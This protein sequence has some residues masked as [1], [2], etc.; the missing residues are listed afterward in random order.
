MARHSS[1]G[2]HLAGDCAQRVGVASTVRCSKGGC[3]CFRA[4]N[5]KAPYNFTGKETAD[6][7]G[8]RLEDESVFGVVECGVECSCACSTCGVGNCLS[9]GE[10]SQSQS[11][12]QQS[13]HQRRQH[14]CSPPPQGCV[15]R[16]INKAPGANAGTG[17]GAGAGASAGAAAA[18]GSKPGRSTSCCDGPCLRLVGP[19]GRLGVRIKLQHMGPKGW[20]VLAD[21]ELT[22]GEYVGTYVGEILSEAQAKEREK[23]YS[24]EGVATSYVLNVCGTSGRNDYIKANAGGAPFAVDATRMGNFA[25]FLNNSCDPVLVMKKVWACG[26]H[27]YVSVNVCVCE[28]ERA[29]ERGGGETCTTVIC[30][31]R[32]YCYI[33]WLTTLTGKHL[34]SWL[35]PMLRSS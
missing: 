15:H 23:K 2:F 26:T 9:S 13:Q 27:Q 30:L 12:S 20:G 1:T 3:P 35:L 16:R 6:G 22:R 34:I 4:N 10:Q 19:A 18:G 25:R 24:A 28:R 7:T 5:Q 14:R 33:C 8:L 21:E 29:R 31:V 32:E 11:Q 17:T